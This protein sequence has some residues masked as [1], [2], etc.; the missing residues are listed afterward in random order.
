MSAIQLIGMHGWAGDHRGWAPWSRAAAA[1]GWS[2]CCG[3][4]GYGQEAPQQP[5]WA[6]G[7]E[8]RV[9]IGHSFG[10]HLLGEA[11]WREATAAVL[12]ASF[13]RFVPE[14]REGRAVN[15][16]LRAMG[17]R[18]RAGEE[19]EQLRDFLQLAASPQSRALLPEGPLEQGIGPNGHKRLLEDLEQLGS[20]S[21]L[22]A[23]F[24]SGIPVLIVEGGQDQIVSAS[25]REELKQALPEATVWS[26][27]ALGHS[28]I[29]PALPDAV[30]D[31]I[32][33]AQT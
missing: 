21:G 23:G 1:R 28:L 16:A 25:S 9:V 13:T 30:L 31:W 4:R 6:S 22:P 18:I 27:S 32:A 7:R 29:D 26:R 15:A 20:T 3:E 8:R 10:P 12:L 2:F 24:P 19:Q 17:R 5:G 33:N 14:G 11:L